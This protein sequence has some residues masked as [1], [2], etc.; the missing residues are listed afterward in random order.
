[1]NLEQAV[2]ISTIAF[3]Q[4]HA[5]TIYHLSLEGFIM[6]FQ[7]HTMP[8]VAWLFTFSRSRL[9]GHCTRTRETRCLRRFVRKPPKITYCFP[10]HCAYLLSCQIF[11]VGFLPLKPYL[12]GFF[13]PPIGSH[14]CRSRRSRPAESRAKGACRGSAVE[15]P[16]IPGRTALSHR[17]RQG[18]P[19]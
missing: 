5:I 13:K 4:T 15:S 19:G 9:E 7:F 10:G 3:L 14:H 2:T 8:G 1:M 17:L 12:T 11:W 6:S 16:H 18:F